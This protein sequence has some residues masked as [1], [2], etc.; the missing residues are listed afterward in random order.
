MKRFLFAIVLFC[1]SFA[2]SYQ[3]VRIPASQIPFH[4]EA[5]VND[6]ILNGIIYF[7][8]YT[9]ACVVFA[10]KFS[11][12]PKLTYITY[13]ILFFSITSIIGFIINRHIYFK[14]LTYGV[15]E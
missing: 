10:K 9:G 13:L 7:L 8:L 3:F 4:G 5:F 14:V 6:S 1:I 15:W 12:H 2:V 11:Y